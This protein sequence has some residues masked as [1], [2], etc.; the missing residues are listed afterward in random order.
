MAEHSFLPIPPRVKDHTGSRFG[1]LTVLGY[2]GFKTQN[3]GHKRPRFLCLCDCG[4]HHE[5]LSVNLMAGLVK[6]CGCLQ[7]ENAA[8]QIKLALAVTDKRTTKTHGMSH[9]PEH[10]TWIRIKQ[11]CGNPNNIGYDLYGGRGI[12]VCDRWQNSFDAFYEDMGP[13]PSDKHSID[14]IDNDGNYEPSNCRWAT[15][16]VQSNNKRTNRVVVFNG[17]RVT[18]SEAEK[19][20]GISQ[21]TLGA[22]LR[23]GVPADKL[24]EPLK[25]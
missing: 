9:G 17:S 2:V 16:G 7:S 23:S 20:C 4:A 12:R 15:V 14:R 8:I 19:L 10:N 6:S 18:L 25:R 13:R 21:K 5:A 22:R 1:R 24:F 11:R 3:D